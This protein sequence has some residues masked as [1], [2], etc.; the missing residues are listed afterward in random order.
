MRKIWS[1]D[2]VRRKM[3]HDGAWDG[4][5]SGPSQDK[6]VQKRINDLIAQCRTHYDEH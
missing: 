2:A 5:T 1:D 6:K 4:Y 3:R